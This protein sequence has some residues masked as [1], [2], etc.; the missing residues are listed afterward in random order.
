MLYVFEAAVDRNFSLRGAR[1]HQ[2]AASSLEHLGGG[3]G[4]Y[5]HGFIYSTL[6]REKL[7]PKLAE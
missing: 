7:K 5:R 3:G 2:E 1:V 4:L 6:L